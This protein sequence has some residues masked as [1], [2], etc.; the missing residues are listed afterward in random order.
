MEA[1]TPFN[2]DLHNMAIDTY[3]ENFSGAVLKALAASSPKR[4]PGDEPRSPI[5]AVIQDEIC[6]KTR[7]RGKWQITKD[8]ALKAKVNRLQR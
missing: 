7:L 4:H 5:T 3:V 1:G 2:P 8:P 6:L